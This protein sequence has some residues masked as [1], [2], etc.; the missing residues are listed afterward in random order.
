MGLSASAKMADVFK[1]NQDG[2]K[3]AEAKKQF[4]MQN[5]SLGKFLD[6]DLAKQF[7]DMLKMLVTQFKNQDPTE[8]EKTNEMTMNLTIM[9]QT[10]QMMKNNKMMEQVNS[11]QKRQMRIEAQ[12]LTGKFT[13]LES[14]NVNYEG[15]PVDIHYTLEEPLMSG[16]LI[17]LDRYKRAYKKIDLDH[18]MPGSHAIKWDGTDENKNDVPKGRYYIKI[19]GKDIDGSTVDVPT[20]VSGRINEVIF[21]GQDGI[22]YRVGNERVVELEEMNRFNYKEGV[23]AENAKFVKNVEAYKKAEA[24]AKK[25]MKNEIEERA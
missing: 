23:Q 13:Q 8:P 19:Q 24:A 21:E 22:A 7:D 15:S 16:Q 12:R 3:R 25:I 18:I 1:L 9:Y 14:D 5:S 20:R 6:K 2:T 10:G 17:I 4:D 11:T